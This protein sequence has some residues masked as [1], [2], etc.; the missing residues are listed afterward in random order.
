MT[1]SSA[2]PVRRLGLG[3]ALV[4]ATAIAVSTES[5]TPEAAIAPAS[6]HTTAAALAPPA[7]VQPRTPQGAPRPYSYRW[8]VKP[9]SK[10][11][12][13]RGFF[14]DP[15]IANHGDSRQFHFGVD[16]SAPNGAP[17]YATLNGT[18]YVHSLHSTTVEVVDSD[19]VEFSY[20][21]IV[22]TI[23]SGQRVVA[24]ETVIGRIEEPY[25][26][27]HFSEKRDG[28]YLNPLR[29]GAMGP[30]VDDTTPSVRSVVARDGLLVAETYDETPLAVPRPWYDLPVMPALVR[31]RLLDAQGR[32]AI[33]WNTAADF[34]LTIPRA[35][36][37]DERWAPGTMQNHV[38]AP[39]RYKVVLSRSLGGLRGRYVVEIAVSDTRGNGERSRFPIRLSES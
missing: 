20:W 6:S 29:S 21:H 30:F 2:R 3:A 22:P 11:H 4:I 39:G 14:G 36:E 27:V 37:F 34:R 18:A 31:W 25:G 10:Q 33:G 13:V 28:R 8:P 35:S 32:V 5:T 17:V 7:T 26:H 15:R 9:F 19:G 16:I 38:R 24:Y 1:P 23:R 12:P